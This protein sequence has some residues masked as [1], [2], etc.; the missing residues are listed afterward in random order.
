MAVNKPHTLPPLLLGTHKKTL[1]LPPTN[2]E[3]L[4]LFLRG[5]GFKVG[6]EEEEEDQEEEECGVEVAITV[7]SH[8]ENG[9]HRF[10]SFSPEFLHKRGRK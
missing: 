8:P 2:A 1:P 9:A 10:Y 4:L 5:R 7:S 3:F 6:W